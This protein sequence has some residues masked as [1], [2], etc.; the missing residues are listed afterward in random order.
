[1]E[2]NQMQELFRQIIAEV[3]TSTEEESVDGNELFHKMQDMPEEAGVVY[4][5]LR[6][7]I[8][9]NKVRAT[10][11]LYSFLIRWQNDVDLL[12]EFIGYVTES[13]KLTIKEKYFLYYQVTRLIFMNPLLE[14][15]ETV[16][17]KWKLLEKV[18][19]R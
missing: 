6:E 1:M 9:G 19:R 3:E 14:T 12:E 13:G 15:R 5:M 2:A 16:L 8:A 10:V 7:C 4:D 11:W 17:A 18:L